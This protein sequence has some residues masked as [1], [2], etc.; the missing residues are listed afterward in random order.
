[1][2]LRAII[3]VLAAVAS[4]AGLIDART[5]FNKSSPP[6]EKKLR[7]IFSF[8]EEDNRQTTPFLF[9]PTDIS[10]GPRGDIYIS[11]ARSNCIYK[12]DAAGVFISQIGRPG[13]GPGEFSLPASITCSKRFVYAH[14]SG[15]QRVQLLDFKGEYQ[16]SF[17]IFRSSSNFITEDDITLYAIRFLFPFKRGEDKLVLAFSK[18]GNLIYEFGEPM[19]FSRDFSI[20]NLCKAVLLGDADLLLA[21]TYQPVIRKYSRKGNLL[22]ESKLDDEF[23]Q[24]FNRENEKYFGQS[25]YFGII[26]DVQARGS[27]AYLLS[28]PHVSITR[29]YEVDADLRITCVYWYDFKE[30]GKKNAARE[31]AV[32][33][34]DDSPIF[35]LLMN[36]SEDK[37]V[38]AFDTRERPGH[39]IEKESCWFP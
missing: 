28:S 4:A 10:A 36:G 34:P 23:I 33:G 2:K 3:I 21:F 25:R 8:P 32:G 14:D 6:P 22:A 11:D 12:Y 30:I 38:F 29:I 31:F 39:T 17:K 18:T 9:D 5:H 1:M 13:Q 24:K 7:L 16:T 26:H 20:L 27:K 37:C 35:Y 15:N 19:D